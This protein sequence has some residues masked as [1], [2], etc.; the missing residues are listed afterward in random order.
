MRN[1]RKLKFWETKTPEELEEMR[2]E[3]VEAHDMISD[4][5][6]E[7]STPEA[8]AEAAARKAEF[9]QICRDLADA[10]TEAEAAIASRF[11]GVQAIVPVHD[12]ED[13]QEWWIFFDGRH[14]L[15]S[16]SPRTN[17]WQPILRAS[18]RVRTN[19][20]DALPALQYALQARR[21]MAPEA[22]CTAPTGG[23]CTFNPRRTKPTWE[24]QGLPNPR[25]K[26]QSVPVEYPEIHE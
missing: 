25:N 18:L 5:V 21:W 15:W 17:A 12:P 26:S 20:P 22:L 1:G 10:I 2:K 7:M 11:A 16:D 19:L 3:L 9:T 24:L 8:L 23:G 14:I 13:N 6:A 4:L